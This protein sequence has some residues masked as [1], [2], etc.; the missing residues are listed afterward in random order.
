MEEQWKDIKNYEGLYQVSNFG[1]VKSL[2]R[3]NKKRKIKKEIIK[4]FTKSPNGYLKAGLSKEGKTKYYFVHRLVA[5]AFIPNLENKPCV[6][7]KDCNKKNNNLSN[8]EWV[9]HEENNSY[10]NHNLK[11]NISSVI[12]YLKKDYC[13]EKNII[14]LAN[15]LKE[16]IDNL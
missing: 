10:K 11:R 15:E 14:K 6:N 3:T 2:P 16:K 9:T 1:R 12:Y 13:N 7:H 5:E 8:L 4:V